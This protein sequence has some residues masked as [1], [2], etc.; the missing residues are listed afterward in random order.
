MLAARPDD[1]QAIQELEGLQRRLKNWKEVRDVLERKLEH[2]SGAQRVPVLEEMAH[3]AEEQLDDAADA[4]ALHRRLLAEAPTHTPSLVALWR[5]LDTAEKWNELAELLEQFM[6][7]LRDLGGTDQIREV[8][9]RLAELYAERLSDP[10]KAR[11]ILSEL[12]EGDP[13]FVPAILALST[14]EEQQGNDEAMRE[15][16]LRAQALQPQGVIGAS[17]QLRLA[18]FADTPEKRR[19]HLETALHLHPANVDAARQLLELSRKEGYWEQVAY[20]LALL[21]QY[22][23][24]DGERKKL[25]LERVDILM[26]K[27]GDPE[28]ALRALAPVYEA[29]QDDVE[30]NRRIADALF[31]SERFD[32]AGGMYGWLIE[33]AAA[34]PKKTKTLSH[35]LTRM[36]R[37]QLNAGEVDPALDRLKEAYRIDTTNP[38]TLVL[39][40]DVYAHKNMWEESLKTARAMLLQ[41]VDQSGLVRRGD[42]YMRLAA[43][44]VGLK[45]PQKAMSMLKRGLEEDPQHPE[46]PARITAL[47]SG[48]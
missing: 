11:Q 38:E 31:V 12:L 13:D 20:L 24:D 16:L 1:L 9:L 32:E 19:E 3:L 29:V 25:I 22:V 23:E 44:H 8:G 34:A 27:V 6:T 37:I 46:I 17:L 30:V 36:A 2:L 28:E 10:D 43:A 5:L 39:L 48:G 41:N 33:V 18:V 26:G 7:V 14:V 40:T 45:E 4:V 35:Y 42:I 47:Q 15:L 21:A